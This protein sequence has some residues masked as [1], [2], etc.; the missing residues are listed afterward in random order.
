MATSRDSHLP[1]TRHHRLSTVISLSVVLVLGVLGGCTNDTRDTPDTPP[2]AADTGTGGSEASTAQVADT[3]AAADGALVSVLTGDGR[4]NT[5][6]NALQA[7]GVAEKLS[8]KGP[9][10]VFA[11]TDQAFQRLPSEILG[12]LLLPEN[13]STL[14][15]VLKYHVLG[16][17]MPTASINEGDQDTLEG[18]KVHFAYTNGEATI[19]GVGLVSELSASNG[20]IHGIDFVLV[21]PGVDLNSLKGS[22]ASTQPT[23][24]PSIGVPILKTLEEQG[25]FTT[26]LSAIDSAGLREQLA[27]PGPFTLFAPT[28]Q[29]FQRLPGDTLRKLLLPGN[30][31]ALVTILRHHVIAKR[32]NGRDLKDQGDLAMLD[33]STAKIGIVQGRI[34]VEDATMTF[35]DR[36]ATNGVIHT[37]DSVLRPGSVD[38]AALTG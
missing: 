35:A 17:L 32:V 2:S 37:I 26:L 15:K 12:K 21:P 31:D 30:R 4:Y 24:S 11:P 34:S 14:E 13:A 10:T 38:L 36:E 27:G 29:A 22:V 5:L 18:K 8:R 33:G 9:F 19:N 23:A 3:G 28:D 6:V 7:S 16:G 1:E 25:N 20:I